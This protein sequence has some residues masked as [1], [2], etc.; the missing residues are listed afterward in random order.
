MG[1]LDIGGSVTVGGEIQ[2]EDL[3]VGGVVSVVSGKIHH[4]DCGGKFTATGAIQV[5][6]LD[7]GGVAV[8]GPD[9]QID[10]IDIGVWR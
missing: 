3:D 7:V 2:C 5:D 9:S 1:S 6:E 8:V 4:V 10:E